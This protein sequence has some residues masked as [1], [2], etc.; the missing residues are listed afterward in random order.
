MLSLFS[1]LRY[2]KFSLWVALW[3]ETEEREEARERGKYI[4]TNVILNA[5]ALASACRQAS[6]C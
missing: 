5:C 4:Q 6:G 1:G 2:Y 3:D